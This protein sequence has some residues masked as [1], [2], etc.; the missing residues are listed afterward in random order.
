MTGLPAL[1][2]DCSACAAYCCVGLAFDRGSRFAIDKPA[3]QPC[4]NL[5]RH[6]C[7]IHDR[8]ASA[9]FAGCAAFD[10]AGAGQRTLA[11]FD[12]L[13]WRDDPARL[14]AQLDTFADLRRLHELLGLLI[15]AGRLPL[16]AGEDRARQDLVAA[17]CP[18]DMTPAAAHAL[19]TGPLP[20]AV[21]DF[22]RGLRHRVGAPAERPRLSAA[23]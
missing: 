6:S 4:A 15:T 8:L 2:P 20:G 22:L 12:R 11:L 5:D 18:D 13:S 10:C 16:D 21:H 3:G 7:T 19:V 23:D 17:L 9:G 14:A 1:V